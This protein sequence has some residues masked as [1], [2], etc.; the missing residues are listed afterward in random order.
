[1]ARLTRRSRSVAGK[2]AIVTGAA[3]GIGR[4]TAQ[5]L[6]DEGARVAVV[7][8]NADRP[9][10]KR[11]DLP[12]EHDGTPVVDADRH[13][14]RFLEPRGVICGLRAKGLAKTDRTGFVRF[15]PEGGS[16]RTGQQ[17]AAA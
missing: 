5:L 12:S 15:V 7:F 16:D 11:W 14:L 8:G 6:A 2:R 3:S 10:A 1:M 4:A 13:D 9:T 17:L